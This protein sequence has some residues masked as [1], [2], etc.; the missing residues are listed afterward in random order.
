MRDIYGEA[1]RCVN[2]QFFFFFQAEAVQDFLDVTDQSSGESRKYREKN[3]ITSSGLCEF[4]RFPSAWGYICSDDSRW[5]QSPL[6][7]VAV[8]SQSAS[9]QT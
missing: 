3:D 1:Q 6:A 5:A 9:L 8:D 2:E 4:L 7:S